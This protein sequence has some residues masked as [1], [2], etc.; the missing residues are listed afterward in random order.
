MEWRGPGESTLADPLVKL[1]PGNQNEEI[2][3]LIDTDAS[4]SVLTQE[5]IPVGHDFVTVIGATGQQKKAFFLQPIEFKI[6]KQ[7]RIHKF[8]YLPE[9]PKSLL[10]Q[11]LLEQLEV[12]IIFEKGKIKLRVKDDR[13][14]EILSLAMI[15]MEKQTEGTPELGEILDQVYP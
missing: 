4:Y 6:G 1:K 12:Q 8:L 13:L 9:S 10:G 15:E 11:D 3:F 7:M 2:E 5:L 14:I